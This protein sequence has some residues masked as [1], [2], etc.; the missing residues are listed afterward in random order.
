MK[1]RKFATSDIPLAG[2]LKYKGCQ[3]SEIVKISDWKAEFIF[4]EVEVSF[5]DEFNNDQSSVE[6]KMF[7]SVMRQLTQSARRV[8]SQQ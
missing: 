8:T 7:A 6:P 5:V 3:I 4:D 1:H 2:Y